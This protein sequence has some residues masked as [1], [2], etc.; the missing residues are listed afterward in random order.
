MADAPQTTVAL[1]TTKAVTEAVVAAAA[2]APVL[3][4]SLLYSP[5]CDRLDANSFAVVPS[6]LCPAKSF[7][8]RQSQFQFLRNFTSWLVFKIYEYFLRRFPNYLARKAG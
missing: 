5:S 2:N 7:V 8:S 3:Q 4:I 1:F 6:Q